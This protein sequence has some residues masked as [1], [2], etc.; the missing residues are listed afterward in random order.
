MTEAERILASGLIPKDYLKPE[1]KCGFYISEER[2]KL[3]AV[4]LE[5]LYQYD[6]VC[7]KYG[8]TYFMIY[9]SLLG[10]VRHKGFIPWDDDLDVCMPREDYEKF[11]KLQ[12]EFKEPLFLQTPYTDKNYFYTP[13]RIRNS[14]TCAAVEL[15]RHMD[16]NQGI[17]F[18]IFPLD[19]WA[20]D[21]GEDRYLE[22]RKLVMHNS[23]FMRS[24]NPDL[25]PKNAARV[26]EWRK[27]NRDPLRDYEEIQRLA[28]A[29]RDPNT[30]YVMTAVITMGQYK[31]KLLPAQC[32][33]SATELDFESIKVSAPVGYRELLTR[34][35]GDFMQ[36]PPVEQRG[37][38]HADAHFDADIS[39]KDY[40]KKQGVVH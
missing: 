9:G 22:I 30:K 39:Y 29:C 15:F 13:A 4:L 17:W 10:A 18:S 33:S 6:W 31:E 37:L 28:S 26:A 8:L 3:F 25:D 27:Q 16:Y 40:L 34:W 2:K 14:N 24:K 12:S 35:Y 19:R 5:M 21:W 23:T 1:E 38:D 11:I 7:K 36:F 20:D 32:F